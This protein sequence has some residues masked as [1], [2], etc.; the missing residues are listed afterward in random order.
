MGQ[1]HFTT[2]RKGHEIINRVKLEYPLSQSKV[3]RAIF[4][5]GVKVAEADESLL[6][7]Q[8]FENQAKTPV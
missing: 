1:V 8:L 6:R 3:I 4:D 2:D 7:K 5:L